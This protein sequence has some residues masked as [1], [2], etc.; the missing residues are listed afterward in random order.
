MGKHPEGGDAGIVCR[1]NGRRLF[2]GKEGTGISCRKYGRTPEIIKERKRSE[3]EKGRG[4]QEKGRGG[5]RG[6]SNPPSLA[7]TKG[8]MP[9]EGRKTERKNREESR[10]EERKE[11]GTMERKEKGGNDKGDRTREIGQGR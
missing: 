6:I 4:K 10:E 7:D 2:A 11:R 8:E 9:N 3:Q 5:G 1:G